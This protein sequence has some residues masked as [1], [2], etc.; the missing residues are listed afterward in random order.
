MVLLKESMTIHYLI[1]LYYVDML[2]N[3]K[4]VVKKTF[5]NKIIAEYIPSS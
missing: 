5:S 4:S 1:P 2:V 3:F